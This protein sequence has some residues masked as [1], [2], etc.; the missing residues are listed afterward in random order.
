MT[1]LIYLRCRNSEHQLADASNGSQPGSPI[2]WHDGR[3]AYC[4]LGAPDEHDWL[5]LKTG[6]SVADLRSRKAAT[7]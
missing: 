3:W 1:P 5:E 7:V 6:H 2:T 4:P